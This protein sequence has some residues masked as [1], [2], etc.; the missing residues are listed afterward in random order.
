MTPAEAGETIVQGI[1]R[2]AVHVLVGNDAK[3]ASVVERLFPVG[4]WRLI[5]GRIGR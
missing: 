1:E 5:A 2:R 4:Y 3:A